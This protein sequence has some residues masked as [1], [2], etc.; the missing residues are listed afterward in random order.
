MF[1]GDN[2]GLSGFSTLLYA[3][4]CRPV[5]WT[6]PAPPPL[7]LA[8]GVPCTADLKVCFFF[9]TALDLHIAEQIDITKAGS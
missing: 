8:R 3:D 9:Y 4:A 2:V 6:P 7:A 1:A 5:M